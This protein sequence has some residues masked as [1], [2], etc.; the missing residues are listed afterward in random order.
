MEGQTS[1][2][3]SK[4]AALHFGV[5]VAAVVV[6]DDMD[7]LARRDFGLD[8]IEKADEPPDAD[9]AASSAANRVVVPWRL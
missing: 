3:G 9:G 2:D 8:R 6:E 1:E 4:R 7:E 5:L